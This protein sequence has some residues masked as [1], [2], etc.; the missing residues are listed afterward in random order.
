MRK[1]ILSNIIR[2]AALVLAVSCT[3]GRL[4]AASVPLNSFTLEFT[5][6]KKLNLTMSLV[7]DEKEI[8]DILFRSCLSDTRPST[9][10]RMFEDALRAAF[11]SEIAAW[12]RYEGYPFHQAELAD[13]EKYKIDGHSENG[14]YYFQFTLELR[15]RQF[16]RHIDPSFAWD[17][18]RER[19]SASLMLHFPFPDIP[20]GRDIST[21]ALAPDAMQYIVVL[22]YP[23]A[24]SQS[25]L[26]DI[27]GFLSA[28]A[29]S[30][31]FLVHPDEY[32]PVILVG[33]LAPEPLPQVKDK[34][35]VEVRD[36]R[37]ASVRA[38]VHLKKDDLRR[39]CGMQGGMSI[40]DA[41]GK[42]EGE[43][44][45]VVGA[46]VP[47]GI[48]GEYSINISESVSELIFN[49]DISIPDLAEANKWESPFE[50]GKVGDLTFIYLPVHNPFD[51]A[52]LEFCRGCKLR[53][54]ECNFTVVMPG[55]IN[56]VNAL[57]SSGLLFKAEG[58]RIDFYLAAEE[59]YSFL[60]IGSDSGR[61]R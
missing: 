30:A 57:R 13:I 56:N 9:G 45:D 42:V 46:L 22:P 19:V 7:V 8:A 20:L 16:M 48:R 59:D 23:I 49:I 52:R 10:E 50:Y 17:E 33:D 32:I 51:P 25:E 53:P 27:T 44:R 61:T 26:S 3:G 5:S 35:E 36:D 55:R 6:S 37:S 21:F 41:V 47:E 34:V 43:Y 24:N 18:G 28:T 40:I 39:A 15:S 4:Y 14:M 1:G 2:L 54:V 29:Y 12:R 38:E 11:D 31:T 58:N 60:T